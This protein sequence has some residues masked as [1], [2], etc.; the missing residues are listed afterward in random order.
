MA[1]SAT[2]HGLK[3][4][5]ATKKHQIEKPKLLLRNPKADPVFWER[6]H[7]TWHSGCPTCLLFSPQ[8]ALENPSIPRLLLVFQETKTAN[9]TQEWLQLLQLPLAD[10]PSLCHS[11]KGKHPAGSAWKQELPALENWKSILPHP[12]SQRHLTVVFPLQ[13][14]IP[15][16]PT[17]YF[18]PWKLL[19]F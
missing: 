7:S 3:G 9:P 13:L 2:P 17:D 18:Q 12:D 1:H 5:F 8:T 6:N 16:L 4:G 19:G 11:F 15:H 14:P 10:P